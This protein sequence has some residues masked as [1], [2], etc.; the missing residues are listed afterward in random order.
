[1]DRQASSEFTSL[2]QHRPILLTSE[3]K[4]ARLSVL[5]VHGWT[6]YR[7]VMDDEER[8]CLR[9]DGTPLKGVLAIVAFPY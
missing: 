7:G 1:M 8:L 5:Y 3:T 6:V 2:N 4:K 9:I